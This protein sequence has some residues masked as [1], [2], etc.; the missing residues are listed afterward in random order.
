[1][2]N[3]GINMGDVRWKVGDTP[4]IYFMQAIESVCLCLCVSA[5]QFFVLV[6]VL[7]PKVRGWIEYI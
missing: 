7:Y 3:I 6:Q 4:E 5:Q 2:Y 1:M